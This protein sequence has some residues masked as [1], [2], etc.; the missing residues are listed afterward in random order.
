MVPITYNDAVFAED[1]VESGHPVILKHSKM[2]WM[3]VSDGY[4]S[5]HQR[6]GVKLKWSGIAIRH[7]LS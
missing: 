1:G 6:N 3:P 5:E 7:S 2:S 4:Y